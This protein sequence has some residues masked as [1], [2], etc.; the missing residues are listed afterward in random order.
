ME[1]ALSPQVSPKYYL[2][3][4]VVVVVVVVVAV[5]VVVLLLLVCFAVVYTAFGFVGLATRDDHSF[6]NIVWS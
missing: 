6:F 3:V 4:V 1:D 2:L 5:A